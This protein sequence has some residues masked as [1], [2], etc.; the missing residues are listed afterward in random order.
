MIFRHFSLPLALLFSLA[1]VPSVASADAESPDLASTVL[2]EVHETILTYFQPSLESDDEIET[3]AI[4]QRH[5]EEKERL[6]KRLSKSTGKWNNNH[7]RHRL[8]DALHGFERH[9]DR[10]NEELDRLKGLYKKAAKHQKKLLEKHIHY[11]D[12]FTSIQHHHSINQALCDKIVAS[13][14]EYYEVPR[15]EL[16]QHI[17]EVEGKGNKAEKMSVSQALK[18]VVRDWTEAGQRERQ[19]TFPCLLGSLEE[20]FPD[21]VDGEKKKVLLPGAGLDRLGHEVEALK[22]FEVTTNEWSMYMNVVYRFLTSSPTIT[23]KNSSTLHPFVDSFSHHIR[24]SQQTRSLS[25]PDVPIDTSAI[26]LTEGD[27]TSVFSDDTDTY[28]VV[29]TYFFIDTARNLM[30]YLDTIKRVLKPGGYWVNLGPLLYGTAPFMQLSLEEILTVSEVMGFNFLEME[31]EKTA[32]RCGVPTF[33]GKKT[34]K[35][36]EAVYSFDDEALT[37]SAYL[38][39]FWVAQLS[40]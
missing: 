26:V 15:E 36:M 25:F 6:L 12:R 34:V 28:D 18:H 24:P 35:G 23:S 9:Y 38:A 16:D 7:P 29:L 30:S 2:T 11:S 20:L 32:E 31:G 39:Q 27:F 21:R 17:K 22:G 4:S 3:T 37:R 5:V 33:E 14:L 19:K 8:L 13:S 10:Q 1:L 40:S